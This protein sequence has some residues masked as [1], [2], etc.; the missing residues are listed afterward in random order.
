MSRSMTRDGF[1]RHTARWPPSRWGLSRH[2]TAAVVRA[3][4]DGAGSPGVQLSGVTPRH[5]WGV[6]LA[7]R[8][9]RS[10]LMASGWSVQ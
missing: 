3:R 9:V 10:A 1:D 8:A 2:F 6:H 4:G 5:W 7:I